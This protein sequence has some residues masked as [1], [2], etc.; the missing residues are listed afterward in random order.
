[1]KQTRHPAG[2]YVITRRS[3]RYVVAKPDSRGSLRNPW[4]G[5]RTLAEA[6]R[7]VEQTLG[8][9]LDWTRAPPKEPP[10]QHHKYRPDR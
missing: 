2:P 5:V 8:Y 4:P 9:P 3:G 10:T 7:D 6:F 1:M